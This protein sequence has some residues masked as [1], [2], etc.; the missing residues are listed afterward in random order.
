MYDV[1]QAALYRHPDFPSIARELY[2]PD[3]NAYSNSNGHNRIAHP[4]SKGS[5][6]FT[7]FEK[8][9]FTIGGR[10]VPKVVVITRNTSDRTT[11]M[12]KISGVSE[13]T[14]VDAFQRRGAKAVVC[15]D[16]KHVNTIPKLVSYFGY[17]DICIGMHG[18][19]MSNC[20]LGGKPQVV[21][22][23]Q[24]HHAFG[25]DN[26]IKIAH[27]SGGSYVFFDSRGVQKVHGVGGGAI[28][29]PQSVESIVDLALNAYSLL[30]DQPLIRI[31][32]PRIG[33]SNGTTGGH[34]EKMFDIYSKDLMVVKTLYRSIGSRADILGPLLS[35]NQK[36]CKTLAYYHFRLIHMDAK[37][38]KF[39]C[40]WP[41]IFATKVSDSVDK[42]YSADALAEHID[43]PLFT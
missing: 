40:D 13:K 14:F 35:A 11:P 36:D 32:Q 1:L 8:S 16:Y 19:G 7:L 20:I 22:E 33:L 42:I 29:P 41:K 25:Y 23:L 31:E 12:R 21:V 2:S 18:A 10:Y 4:A 26:Y 38:H 37:E 9:K 17:A 30:H 43:R 28:I 24:N 3:S 39:R 5:K 34:V 15:C 6:A 27:M